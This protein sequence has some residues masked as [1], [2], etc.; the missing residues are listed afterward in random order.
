MLV[1]DYGAIL[2]KP[3]LIFFLNNDSEAVTYFTE[4]VNSG[5]P[6]LTLCDFT[7]PSAMSSIDISINAAHNLYL[8]SS[9]LILKILFKHMS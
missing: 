8:D 3:D 5:I 2:Q 9:I 1:N 6:L 7:R 4:V